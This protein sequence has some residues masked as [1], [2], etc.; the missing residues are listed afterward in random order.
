MI[1]IACIGLGLGFALSCMGFSEYDEIRRMFLFEDLRLL[2]TFIG[3]LILSTIVFTVARVPRLQTRLSKGLVPG[4]LFFGAG[5]A[6]TGACPSISLVQ[7]G[8][9]YWPALFTTL[10]IITGVWLHR[11]VRRRFP[12]WTVSSCDS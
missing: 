7:L 8:G 6:L 10:G 5:W 11:K 1:R 4:G 3:A 9:G 2:F 12:D